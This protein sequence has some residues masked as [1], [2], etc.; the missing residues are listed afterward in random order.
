MLIVV[1][2][3]IIVLIFVI[4]KYVVFK[5]KISQI[6]IFLG[7]G[8]HTGEMLEIIQGFDFNKFKKLSLIIS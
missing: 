7:S 3:F 4:L 5:K 2:L 1:L 6:C 8:G